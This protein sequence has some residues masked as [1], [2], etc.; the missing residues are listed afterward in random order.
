M[1]KLI[2]YLEAENENWRNTT[3]ILMDNAPYHRSKVFSRAMEFLRV[4]LVYL[5]PY[6]FKMAPVE[7][8]FAYI[9]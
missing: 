2:E 1:L 9:K 5:G 6:Q 4:P 3:I 7:L 8:C